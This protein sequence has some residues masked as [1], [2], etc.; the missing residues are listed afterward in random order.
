MNLSAVRWVNRADAREIEEAGVREKGIKR[1][2]EALC[3]CS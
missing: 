1:K 3:V 2:R